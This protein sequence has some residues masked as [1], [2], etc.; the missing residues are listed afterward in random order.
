MERI[1]YLYV[2]QSP[3]GL[4]YLGITIK[5]PYKYI[6]S[7]IY[8]KQHLHSH[9]FL[10]K[11]ITTE[12]IFSSISHDEIIKMGLYYS[13]LWNVVDSNDWANLTP[14]AGFTKLGSKQSVETVE[15]RV[16]KLR[17]VHRSKETI[18]KIRIANTGKKKSLES[19]EKL[20]TALRGKK[21]S[22][23]QI[24]NRTKG[25]QGYRHSEETKLKLKISNGNKVRN[26]ITGDIYLSIYDASKA[27]NIK[28]ENLCRQLLYTPNKCKIEYVDNILKVK[29]LTLKDTVKVDQFDLNGNFIRSFS[30]MREAALDPEVKED[31]SNISACC[32]GIRNSA[33]KFIWKYKNEK[34]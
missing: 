26:K 12:I 32:R 34:L 1:I 24:K 23:E 3:T 17:G 22:P 5:N 6:G 8:W 31:S 7:G 29:K 14:E 4:K 9:K 10:L 33:Y 16:S 19:I 2:K 20:K 13:N 30:S 21:Q 15:K 25:R 28:R 11:D 27:L 18:E